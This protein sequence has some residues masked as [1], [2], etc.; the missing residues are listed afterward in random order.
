M[1]RLPTNI[2]RGRAKSLYLA[3]SARPMAFVIALALFATAP[4]MALSGGSIFDDDF[5]APPSSKPPAPAYVPPPEPA[6]PPRLPPARPAP[7][8]PAPPDNPTPP[9]DSPVVKPP[10]A[11]APDAPA[12]RD[13][14][15]VPADAALAPADKLVKEVFKAEYSR[16][17]TPAGQI[18]L[19]RALFNEAQQSRD[20]A[21]TL[22][23]LLR[24]ARDN[25]SA[26]GDPET[27]I[28]ASRGLRDAFQINHVAA[29]EMERDALL[30]AVKV[31][32]AAPPTA[33]ASPE[34]RS[35][36]YLTMA[37]AER[38]LNA[39]N[40]AQAA[41]A[42]GQAEQV[43]R[44][45]ND[46]SLLDRVHGRAAVLS[47]AAV[48]YQRIKDQLAALK[49]SPDDAAANLAVGRFY[50]FILDRPDRGMQLLARSSDRALKALAERE[51][52]NP[53]TPADQLA[54]ADAW[55][56]A[57]KVTPAGPIKEGMLRR[58]LHWYDTAGP[59]LP[60]LSKIAAQKK[61][62]ELR[63]NSLKHGLLG[64][65]YRGRDFGFKA[66]TRVDPRIEY[67]WRGLPPD[68][69][70]PAVEFSTR[71]TG[72]IKGGIAGQYKLV[73]LHDDGVRIWIDGELVVDHWDDAG[74]EERPVHLT[75]ALQEIK[76]DYSQFGGDSRMGLGWIPPRANK[77]V[78]ISPEALFHAPVPAGPVVA[79]RPAPDGDGKILLPA[80]AADPHNAGS[81]F[82]AQRD[83][84]EGWFGAWQNVSTWLSWD[85]DAPEGDYDVEIDHACDG[86]GAGSEYVL[87][88]GGS[89]ITAVVTDTGGW[90]NYATKRLGRVRLVAGGQT[91]RI[92]PRTKGRSLVMDLHRVILTP[93]K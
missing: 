5:K 27:A 74:R 52:V 90:S 78:A 79:G 28:D 20:D 60:G 34:S 80:G 17:T 57:A 93:V 75:G 19:A 61:A 62:T 15:K 2:F 23:V 76:I 68:D 66:L 22:Y 36:I 53:T 86:E 18:A 89:R 30:S 55:A 24:E 59:Q 1:I 84:R 82:F 44:K 71:W 64:E 38:D 7:D 85:F 8:N 32:L 63:A 43:A 56:A 26:G 70:M 81:A 31:V 88:V 72:W 3:W 41:Q 33:V 73:V 37:M 10:V 58:A 14:A 4:R 87:S 83:G 40:Y 77:A 91:L 54:V 39:G 6:A 35:A 29:G 42:A 9:P 49:A 47:T 13:R 50:A 16:A 48:E 65:Y 92:K 46:P 51:I 21:V 45:I 11:P 67:N 69:Y 12:L 25:A